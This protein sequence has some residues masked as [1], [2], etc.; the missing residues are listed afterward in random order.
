M[1]SGGLSSPNTTIE[2][3]GSHADLPPIEPLIWCVSN[4]SPIKVNNVSNPVFETNSF[5][6]NGGLVSFRWL[7]DGVDFTNS[8]T[9]GGRRLQY[10]VTQKIFN[11]TVIASSNGLSSKT[12][13]QFRAMNRA[14]SVPLLSTEYPTLTLNSGSVNRFN[15]TGSV[16]ADFDNISYRWSVNGIDYSSYAAMLGSVSVLKQVVRAGEFYNVSVWAYDGFDKSYKAAS[17]FNYQA[18]SLV[19][20]SV[21]LAY[22]PSFFLYR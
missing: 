13:T 16:D 8:A 9:T 1:D 7:V 14:P 21:N 5:D 4:C 18:N 19:K 12:T 2:V 15:G 6:P 11:V 3:N 17:I 10:N 22:F 20:E